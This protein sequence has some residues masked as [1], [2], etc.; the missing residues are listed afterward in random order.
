MGIV[1]GFVVG[2]VLSWGVLSIGC[3]L[4]EE[5]F[6]ADLSKDKPYEK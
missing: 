2:V 5:Y 4:I 1:I 3:S 6:E